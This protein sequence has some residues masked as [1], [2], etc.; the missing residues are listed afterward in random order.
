MSVVR[1]LRREWIPITLVLALSSGYLSGLAL[2]VL[3]IPPISEYLRG[4]RRLDPFTF[5]A[6]RT[7]DDAS[8][9]IGA[10][11]GCIRQR[12][13]KPL[14]PDLRTWRATVN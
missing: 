10:W 5:I 7:L 14:L 13:I 11:A 8:Y 12:T 1:A 4:P 9:G 2:A 3:V 6:L